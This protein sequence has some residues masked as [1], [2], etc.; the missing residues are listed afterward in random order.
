MDKTLKAVKE[1]KDGLRA[2]RHDSRKGRTRTHKAVMLDVRKK[3]RV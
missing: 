1:I 3:L 2:S